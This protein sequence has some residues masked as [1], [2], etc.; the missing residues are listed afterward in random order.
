MY[1]FELKYCNAYRNRSGGLCFSVDGRILHKWHLV[2]TDNKE[3]DL[4]LLQLIALASCGCAEYLDRLPF[5]L[6]MLIHDHARRPLQLEMIWAEHC[7]R[8]GE[9]HPRREII[10]VG[11]VDAGPAFIEL[12]QAGRQTEPWIIKGIFNAAV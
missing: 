2:S 7:G 3:S 8:I 10:P 4:E 11:V 12:V 5:D 1:I 6:A 9:A